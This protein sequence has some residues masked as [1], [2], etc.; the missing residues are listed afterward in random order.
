MSPHKGLGL[1]TDSDPLV[2]PKVNRSGLDQLTLGFIAFAVIFLVFA[3]SKRFFHLENPRSAPTPGA[4]F[5][6]FRSEKPGTVH[7]ITAKDLPA[8]Y[9]TTSARNWPDIVDRPKNAWP[10]AP[11]GFKVELFATGL[12]EPRKI[13]TAPK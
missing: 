13:T 9:A 1:T 10:Q 2:G 11:A 5:S 3:V 8:P 6:D 12:D 4:P 7:K